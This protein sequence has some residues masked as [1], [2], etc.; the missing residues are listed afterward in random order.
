MS[1]NVVEVEQK[2]EEIPI[3]KEYPDVFPEDIPEFPPEREI[4]FTIELVLGT[5]PISIAPYRM[6][7]LELT[8]VKRQIEEL[9][10]KGFIRPSASPWGAPVPLVKKKDR[11]MRLCMDYRQLNK[12]KI[13]N[14][15]P[16]P[17]IDDL[18]DQLQGATVFSR[19]TCVPNIIKFGFGNK[20]SLR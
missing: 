12:V 9:L 18:M 2:L 17:R 15:Y 3:V 14:K 7:P 5:G 19:L 8:E 1:T 10:G 11:G 20:T 4:E 16:L 13:K 6:S